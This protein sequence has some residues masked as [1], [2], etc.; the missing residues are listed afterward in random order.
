[1]NIAEQLDKDLTIR[2]RAKLAKHNVIKITMGIL[3]Y[4]TVMIILIKLE[5]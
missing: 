1:M 4:L 3:F 5:I 2:Q